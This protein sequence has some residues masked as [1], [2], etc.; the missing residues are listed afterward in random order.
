MKNHSIYSTKQLAFSHLCLT[1][2]RYD[3]RVIFYI[4]PTIDGILRTED[5]NV[6]TIGLPVTKNENMKDKCTFFYFIC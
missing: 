2:K 5:K 1:R 4:V 3:F 6:C